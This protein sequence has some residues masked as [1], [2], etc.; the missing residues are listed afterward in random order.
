MRQDGPRNDVDPDD[1]LVDFGS[2]TLNPA[3]DVKNPDVAFNR[4]EPDAA[5]DG[6][7]PSLIYDSRELDVALA[8]KEPD[9]AFGRKDSVHSFVSPWA[10]PVVHKSGAWLKIVIALLIF[11]SIGALA[12]SGRL[13]MGMRR[14]ADT[15]RPQ[16]QSTPSRTPTVPPPVPTN[17]L[18]RAPDPQP[19]VADV[20]AETAKPSAPAAGIA[21]PSEAPAN[22]PDAAAPR[23]ERPARQAERLPVNTD[24]NAAGGLFAITRPLG[25]QVFLDNKLIGTTPFFMSQ[26]SSGPH[27]VRLE[28]PGFK[29]YS[30][31]IQVEPN[32]R[33]RL[34][35]QL[36][37]GTR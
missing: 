30:S 32:Q 24:P 23:V 22:A 28:L 12:W 6:S 11:V 36:D 37:E 25:A 20:P 33:F 17:V 19:S 1:G 35:V 3:L 8:G 27:E 31:S 2:E 7:E 16:I 21:T 10:V 14:N 4:N 13:L 18:P 9:S 34:A 26:L 29:T 5:T 15:S